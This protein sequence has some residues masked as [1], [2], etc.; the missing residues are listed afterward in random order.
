MS[1]FQ[2]AALESTSPKRLT[3]LA[4]QSVTLARIVA[5]NPT[6]P[7]ELLKELADVRASIA[8]NPNAPIKI[9]ETLARDRDK[10]VRRLAT[11]NL[12]MLT[13]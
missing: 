11:R 2:E 13:T 9:L 7:A 8:E 12:K 3:A 10:R 5:A 1:P 6:A 4:Q